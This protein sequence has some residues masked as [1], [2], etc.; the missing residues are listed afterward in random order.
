MWEEALKAS[1]AV[2]AATTPGKPL[3]LAVSLSHKYTKANL[4]FAN[5]KG[6]DL[7]M[8][9][10]LR[11]SGAFEVHLALIVRHITGGG[12]EEEFGYG[13]YG[14]GRGRWGGYRYGRGRW[15]GYGYEDEE[16]DD[17]EDH[18]EDEDDEEDEEESSPRPKRQ[19]GRHTMV[20]LCEDE[21]S[22]DKWVDETG[23][24]VKHEGLG[25][26]SI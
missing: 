16:E 8:A 5:L 14:Y 26:I 22:V 9:D 3:K 25:T 19:K 21:V 18:V 12:D 17:D 1:P 15:G 6:R 2:A 11:S 23:A 20:D 24:T 10:H 7:M 13:E 4:D